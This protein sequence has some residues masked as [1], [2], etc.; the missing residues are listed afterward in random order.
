MSVTSSAT[1]SGD[2]DVPSAE[3]I[4]R[5]RL[6]LVSITRR[7]ETPMDASSISEEDVVKICVKKSHTHPLGVLCYSAMETVMLFHTT[8]KLKHV[9]CGII[10]TMEFWGEAIM[11]RAMAPSEAHVAAYIAMLHRNPSNREKELQTPP[12]WRNT[13][14]PPCGTWRP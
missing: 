3:V 1:A 5:D 2:H 8:G 6:C 12:K 14:S 11:V 4:F 13:T 9:T 10:E 7:D